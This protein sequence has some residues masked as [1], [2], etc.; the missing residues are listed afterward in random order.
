MKTEKHKEKWYKFITEWVSNGKR[1]SDSIFA[2]SRQEAEHL[3]RDKKLT[4]RIV[5]Y[6]PEKS[7]LFD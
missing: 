2:K 1:Y 4:E 3:L 6:D 7:Y 5:G